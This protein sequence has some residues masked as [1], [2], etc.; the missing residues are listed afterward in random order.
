M[1]ST[2]IN[3]VLRQYPGLSTVF[4]PDTPKPLLSYSECR[5]PAQLGSRMGTILLSL[6]KERG[7][8]LHTTVA[9]SFLSRAG[10]QQDISQ[11]IP[12]FWGMPGREPCSAGPRL[13]S[14]PA[15]EQGVGLFEAS[16]NIFREL[17]RNKIGFVLEKDFWGMMD[18]AGV[19]NV[20]NHFS[21]F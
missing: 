8:G 10:L 2:L 5:S 19:S 17:S 16:E 15:A 21:S 7:L 9:L 1:P 18:I 14:R 20:Q 12:G 13:V 6:G 11:C 4:H 3:L